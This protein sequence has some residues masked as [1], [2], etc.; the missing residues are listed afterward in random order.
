MATWKID[1]TNVEDSFPEIGAGRYLA[2]VKSIESKKKDGGEYSYLL[3]ELT[4]LTGSA[5]GQTIRHM[6][7]LNPKGLFNL[8]DTL[9]ALGLK[10]PKSAVNIDPSKLIGKQMCIDVVSEDYNGKSYPKVK[11]TLLASE[12]NQATTVT[13]TTSVSFDTEDDVMVLTDDDL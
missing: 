11:K 2:K 4:I 12:F 1:F 3:W 13:P 8:R 6:T 10:V 5:K 9:I 7:T